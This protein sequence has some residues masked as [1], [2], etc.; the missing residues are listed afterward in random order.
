MDTN[1]NRLQQRL[2]LITYFSQSIFRRNTVDDVLW[3][4]VS[5]CIDRLGFED[6]VI[7][8]V[9]GPRDVLVQKAAYG[10]KNINFEA[11]R[12]PI[13]IPIGEGIVGS[14]ARTGTPEIVTDTRE[15]SR[16]IIDDDF[17]LSELAV[18]II[19]EG[20]VIGVIDSEHSEANFYDEYHL[21][22]LQDLAN[23]SGT[24]IEK[25]IHEDERSDLTLM[26][27]EN[28]NPVIKLNKDMEI[29]LSNRAAHSVGA[30]IWRMSLPEREENLFRHVR[31][32]FDEGE[33]KNITLAV[34]GQFFSVEIVPFPERGYVNLYLVEITAIYEAKEEAESAN[35]AKTDFISVMSH[36]IRTPL[37]G[38]LNLNRL[39]KLQS[40]DPELLK[41]LET[42]EYSGESL[43]SII[44][45]IL[46]FE[47]L[48]ARKFV[49]HRISFS[50][51][52]T[53]ARL[54]SLMAP[55]A[56]EKAN[57]LKYAVTRAVPEWIHCDENRLLQVISNL[58]NNA[59]NFTDNGQVS[60]LVDCEDTDQETMKL[61]V[62][63][64]DT[65]MGIPSDKIDS[66]FDSYEQVQNRNKPGF[67]GSG[68][69]LAIAQRLVQQQDG[70]L[71]VQSE[72]GQGAEFTVSLPVTVGE[73]PS[74]AEAI[75]QVVE[76]SRL[77]GTRIMVVDDS[78]INVLAAKEFLQKWSAE[79]LSATDGAEAV[80]LFEEN[81]VDLILMDLQMPV[82]DGYAATQAIRS[83]E[84][85]NSNVPIIAM[86]ADV[87]NSSIV[88][89]RNAGMDDHLS[90][91]FNPDELLKVINT[92]MLRKAV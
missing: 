29:V 9:D 54:D 88:E 31:K 36:E 71:T 90:K 24:K 25:T 65:G 56:K 1:V 82:M 78:P 76:S 11:V 77:E 3:D 81:K 32:A 34:N 73:E 44:N 42:I 48:E 16:Y 55:K 75:G 37:N 30:S 19:S 86:S 7:Y 50:V 13:E 4:I 12:D 79:V 58:V 45:D 62:M 43:L 59:L 5:N 85:P 87:L 18:P 14:V 89:S 46:D 72:P 67:E 49:F 74:R 39:V 23:I 41:H 17:R 51:R 28:P 57:T 35:R 22:V 2:E 21:E 83:S 27:F 47:K 80:A 40:N 63:V 38:I 92:N 70:T 68:L 61:I 26:H 20:K 91:P 64:K 69:G 84:H 6:C 15:D 52:D 33:R 60:I 53:M 66:I 10:D 8:L